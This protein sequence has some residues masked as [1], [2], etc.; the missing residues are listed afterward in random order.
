MTGQV[1]MLRLDPV[2]PVGLLAVV[3]VL[4]VGFSLWRLARRP[5]T[6]V[7]WALRVVMVILLL[8][9]SLR[10]VV[11]GQTAG[12]VA[13]GGLEV[14][15]VV[16]TTSSMAAEDGEGPEVRLDSAIADIEA[17]AAALPGAQYSLTTFDATTLQRV[18]LTSDVQALVSAASVLTTEVTYYSRGS[19][20]SEPVAALT[21][22]LG[23]AQSAHPD[24]RRVLFYLGDGEQTRA[25]DPAS[26]A[27]L[28]PY[29]GGGGVLGYGTEEGG[30]MLVFDGFSADDDP[31]APQYI[32]DPATGTDAV[33]RI[34]ETA[35]Q[36]IATQ[37][38]VGY[39]HRGAQADDGIET[40]VSRIDVGETEITAGSATGPVEFYWIFAIPLA[41]PALLET[42]GAAIAA[43]AARPRRKR[44]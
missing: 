4:L 5:G 38:Q 18:P 37:L 14:Y 12:P 10:P 22:L 42:I 8:V 29:I 11:P 33:S 20:I 34:D 19:S 24:R 39:H 7:A 28:T 6:R 3:A 36:T 16:D 44:P 15:F 30:R 32:R 21:T 25:D 26:F 40:V 35:L 43:A 23:D 31:A 13:T 27:P 9:I 41:L 17:I 1:G 2:L